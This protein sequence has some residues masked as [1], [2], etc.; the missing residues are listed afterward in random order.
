MARIAKLAVDFGGRGKFLADS[1]MAAGAYGA[2]AGPVTLTTATWLRR[3][4]VHAVWRGGRNVLASL[5]FT[6]Q[7][8]HWRADP[9][10]HLVVRAWF[11]LWEA[12][13]TGTWTL[14]STAW[15][16]TRTARLLGGRLLRPD[17]PPHM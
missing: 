8:L 11:F 3:W 16:G 13:S 2:G 4:A 15:H 5:L 10:G 7:H 9:V 6:T 12:L 1:A 14:R 17:K